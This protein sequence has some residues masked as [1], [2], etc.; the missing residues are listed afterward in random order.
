[1]TPIFRSPSGRQIIA[2]NGGPAGSVTTNFDFNPVNSFFTY[3]SPYFHNPLATP[4]FMPTPMVTSPW[5]LSQM[6]A[7]ASCLE[8]PAFQPVGDEDPTAMN[9]IL[10]DAR[11]MAAKNHVAGV[12]PNFSTTPQSTNYRQENY[13]RDFQNHHNHQRIVPRSTPMMTP[14]FNF[15]TFSPTKLPNLGDI[16]DR[17]QQSV[18]PLDRIKEPVSNLQCMECGK[19]YKKKSHL[20]AHFRT[21]TGE[22]PF[23]CDFPKCESSFVRS[24]E[25]KRHKR[26]HTGERPYHCDTCG[27]SFARS[28]HLLL[29]VRRMKHQRHPYQLNSSGSAIQPAK[30]RHRNNEMNFKA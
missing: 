16:P 14:G 9:K 12:S 7:Q 3:A 2:T 10:E 6:A 17:K 19:T 15:A 30:T 21:H 13:L 8:T 28:D 4:S 26:I 1:M 25:L 18:F 24:D 23:S 27:K 29:H 5:F 22:K 20:K 11:Q